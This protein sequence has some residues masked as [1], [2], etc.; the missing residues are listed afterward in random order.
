MVT[1]DAQAGTGPLM[2]TDCF[3]NEFSGGNYVGKSIEMQANSALRNGLCAP[4]FFD[5]G[6]K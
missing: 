5:A 3:G 4:D 6:K 1:H 2:S